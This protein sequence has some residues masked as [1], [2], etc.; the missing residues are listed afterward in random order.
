MQIK[1][2]TP[3]AVGEILNKALPAQNGLMKETALP[4]NTKQKHSESEKAQLSKILARVCAL[5]QQYGKT[6]GEL[7]TL[8]EGFCWVLEGYSM[9][10]IIDAI[11]VYLKKSAS[12]PTPADIEAIINPPLPN[13]EWPLYITMQKK[14][15][16]SNYNYYFTPEEKQFLHD[17]EDLAMLR[18]R[19]EMD[20]YNSSQLQLEN[21][22]NLRL[23]N[24]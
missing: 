20:N 8:V 14:K 5:Q 1:A 3:K 18:Q 15:I 12:I 6:A 22:K 19:G 7:E 9:Q 24:D 2:E 23:E 17:C 16:D 13:I 10:Q 4:Q 11:A 21:Y